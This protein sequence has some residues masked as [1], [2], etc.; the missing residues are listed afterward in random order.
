MGRRKS[1]CAFGLVALLTVASPRLAHAQSPAQI[2]QAKQWFAEGVSL[3][4][5]E[6]WTE[7]L[8]FFRR[9]SLVK[10]T[11]QL[12]YHLGVCEGRSGA[13]VEALSSLARASE[14]ARSANVPT[15][16][17]A[18]KEEAEFVR[19][20]TPTLE[21]SVR[22][23][24]TLTRLAI[25]GEQVAVDAASAPLPMNAGN[26]EVV[27]EFPTGT[28]KKSIAL[29]VK[30]AARMLLEA[31][32]GLS[33]VPL[34]LIGTGGAAVVGGVIFYAL[35][36]SRITFLDAQCTANRTCDSSKLDLHDAVDS[37]K[38]YSALSATLLTLGVVGMATGGGLMI[39]GHKSAGP[40]AQLSPTAGGAV[41]TGRF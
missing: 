34:V 37:G 9:A 39:L 27:A 19:S 6:K 31:P 1:A 25:D 23:G 7:A 15:V 4:S 40:N 32:P 26:H 11:P 16:D 33:A 24:D 5:R 28:V 20:R 36:R 13:F 35:A 41:I 38:T 3:E 12:A 30:E 8:V 29:H 22:A 18:A 10:M 2:T 14:L 17:S 21:L